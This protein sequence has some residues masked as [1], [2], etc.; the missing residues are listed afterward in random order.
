MITPELFKEFG[1]H[2][3]NFYSENKKEL[4]KTELKERFEKM[5][6]NILDDIDTDVNLLLIKKIRHLHGSSRTMS[7]II[8]GKL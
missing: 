8:K 1:E 5:C 3:F 7:W 4:V 6:E 2:N